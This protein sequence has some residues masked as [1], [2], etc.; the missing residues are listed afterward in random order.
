MNGEVQWLVIGVGQ[1]SVM[2]VFTGYDENCITMVFRSMLW[3]E[4]CY[5]GTEP[6]DIFSSQ[7]ASMLPAGRVNSPAGI[8]C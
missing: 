6:V 4:D 1:C 7:A 3:A 5:P 2:C 8:W